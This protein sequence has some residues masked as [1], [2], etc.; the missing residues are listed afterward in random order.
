MKIE[1]I[2]VYKGFEH[3]DGS[4]RF[5]GGS[6]GTLLEVYRINQARTWSSVEEAFRFRDYNA[7]ALELES[8][9]VVAVRIQ[10]K[11]TT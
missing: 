3:D 6:G 4:A 1:Y 10:E 2:L 5:V 11:R 9:I 8:Y 7:P